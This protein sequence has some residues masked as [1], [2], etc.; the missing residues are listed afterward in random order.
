MVTRRNVAGIEGRLVVRSLVLLVE[1][2]LQLGLELIGSALRL[3]GLERIH[4]RAV[5]GTER[6]QQFRRRRRLLEDE[7]VLFEGDVAAGTPAAPN[8]SITCSSTPHV[9]GLTK[10]SGGGGEYDAL[11]FRICATSVG[12]SGIQLP[13]TMRPPGRATRTISF[14]TS[15][16]LGREHRTE[17]AHDEIEP[18]VLEVHEI[19]G[20]ALLET[21]SS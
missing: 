13:M 20:V 8:R 2:Q 7:R 1:E 16:G 4:R 5:I 19:G 9:I 10:P 18:L 15:N 11:I 6:G 12:S 21:A 17:D 14:A 3:G